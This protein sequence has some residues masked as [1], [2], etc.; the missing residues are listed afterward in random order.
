LISCSLLKLRTLPLQT[1]FV[2]SA[3]FL[4]D[5]SEADI[6][7]SSGASLDCA[8]GEGGNGIPEAVWNPAF[9]V[10]AFIKQGGV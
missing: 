9:M 7:A 4:I 10:R 1:S 5:S 2:L 6:Q 3:I 8:G